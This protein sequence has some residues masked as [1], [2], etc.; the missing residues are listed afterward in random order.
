MVADQQ[1][2]PF[3]CENVNGKPP[4]GRHNATT[5]IALSISQQ[6]AQQAVQQAAEQAAE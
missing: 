3:D 4:L 6:A 5:I 2:K 1:S